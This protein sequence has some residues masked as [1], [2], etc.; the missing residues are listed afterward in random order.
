[1]GA[2]V[3]RT[4]SIVTPENIRVTYQLAGFASRFMAILVDLLI[5]FALV[6]LVAM[7]A[8]LVG[9]AEALRGIGIGSLLSALGIIAIFLIMFA[10]AL[11]FEAFW[12]GRTPGKRLFGLRVIREG[13]YPVT[14]I[15]SATRNILRF[16]DYG[17]FPFSGAPVFL[18]GLPGLIA[19]FLSP[20]YKRIGD[21][22]A[23]TLVIVE[24]KNTPFG[25]RSSDAALS[26]AAAAF[27]PYLRNLDRLTRDEYR[28]LRRFVARRNDLEIPIQAA[29]AEKIARRILPRLEIEAPIQYQ[30]QFADLL[31][32][33]ER[34][35]AEEQGVL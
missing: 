9:G 13:G 29:L 5:Q 6:M 26:P 28:V 22:A 17:V 16:A 2:V 1:M 31:E 25:R 14:F 11:F 30:L 7:L 33:L 23:G 20:R 34:R 3:S 27:L 32:A 8:R 18:F 15:A 10:Y 4:V 21:Y 24:Q 19:I 35:Y 12:G